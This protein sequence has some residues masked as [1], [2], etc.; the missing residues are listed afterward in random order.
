MLREQIVYRLAFAAV[1]AVLPLQ[2]YIKQ[3]F[4]EPYPSLYMPDFSGTGVTNGRL[5]TESADIQVQFCDGRTLSLTPNEFFSG[6][7]ISIVQS[8]MQW[9]F[10]PRILTPHQIPRW[11]NWIIRY[12]SPG[13]GRRML[14]A[15][16]MSFLDEPTKRWI[17]DQVTLRFGGDPKMFQALWYTDTYDAQ[18]SFPIRS[19]Q[20]VSIVPVTFESCGR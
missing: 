10:G 11:K 12:V 4:G 8:A 16:G 13:Y 2:H 1:L 7:P 20:L 18:K 5:Q 9:M 14:R 6:L 17:H 19:R 15:Q 3:R